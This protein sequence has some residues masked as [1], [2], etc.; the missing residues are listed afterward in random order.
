MTK[1]PLSSEMLHVTCVARDGRAILIGGR[2]GSGKS[3]L[4]LRLMDRGAMLVSDDYT[5]VRRIGGRLLASAPANIHG[6]MEVRGVG[7]LEY[8]TVTDVQVCLF[9]SLDGEVERLPAE[10][11]SLTVAGVA[12]PLVHVNGLEASAPLKVEAALDRF[13]LTLP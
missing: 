10:H 1:A 8:E 9:V 3:D 13:G 5:L 12:V 2:S 11:S 6:M 7:V 4:A